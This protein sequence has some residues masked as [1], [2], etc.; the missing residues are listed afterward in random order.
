M[1][2]NLA[3]LSGH[4]IHCSDLIVITIK[5]FYDINKLQLNSD[6]NQV[7]IHAKSKIHIKKAKDFSFIAN[8][9]EIKNKN[10]IKILGVYLNSELKIGQH[11]N[12]LLSQCYNKVHSIKMVSK[13]QI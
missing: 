4:L 5:K 11:L 13:I 12:S 2:I 7:C 8:K 10:S 1:S 3:I 6:K 9:Y